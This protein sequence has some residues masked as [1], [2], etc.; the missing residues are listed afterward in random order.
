MK[1][2]DFNGKINFVDENNVFLGYSLE[3][4][5]CENAG[6]FISDKIESTIIEENTEIEQD[7]PKLDGYVF[8]TTFFKEAEATEDFDDGGM[9][10]FR[11]YKVTY[12]KPFPEKFIHLYNVHNG[13]YGHGFAFS[14]PNNIQDGSI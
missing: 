5:C 9:V 8:D 14:V 2:F 13:Y 3:Q 4:S 10:I 1:V 7:D 6:W 12:P 11:I